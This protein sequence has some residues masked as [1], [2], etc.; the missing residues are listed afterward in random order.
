MNARR[1]AQ[2]RLE[3]LENRLVMSSWTAVP[4]PDPTPP[5]REVASI[6]TPRLFEPAITLRSLAELRHEQL[7]PHRH[8]IAMASSTFPTSLVLLQ[9]GLLYRYQASGFS[10]VANNVIAAGIAFAPSGEEI[11]LIVYRGGNLFQYAG[12][13]ATFISSDVRSA[14]LVFNTSGVG[15]YDIVFSNG[16]L[17]QFYEGKAQFLTDNVRSASLALTPSNSP[18]YLIV[19]TNGSLYQSSAAGTRYITSGLTSASIAYPSGSFSP[20]FMFVFNDGLLVFQRPTGYVIISNQGLWA[21][22]TF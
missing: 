10:F 14:S 11:D 13:K 12:G 2:P 17:F 5:P 6:E 19:F 16:A 9:G 7:H 15:I 20:W 3:N 1:R 22:L 8:P 18:V 4:H 21:S